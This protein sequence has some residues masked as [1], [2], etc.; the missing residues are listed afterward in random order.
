MTTETQTPD[1]HAP[2]SRPA[3]PHAPGDGARFERRPVRPR[4]KALRILIALLLIAA[5]LGGL[6][7]FNE[8]RKQMIASFFAGNVPPPTPVQVAEA[9]QETVPRHLGAIGTLEAVREVTV[10][11][12]V[13]GRVT[14]IHFESGATVAAGA[15]LVQLNDST[16]RA[17]LLVY[18]AQARLAELNLERSLSLLPRQAVPQTTVDQNRAELDQANANIKRIEAEI[19]QKLIRAPFAGDLGIRAVNLGEFVGAGATLVTLTDLSKLLV[20]FTLPEQ[21]RSR[22]HVGQAVRIESDAFPDRAFDG[23][24][25]TVDPQV[26]AETRAIKIQATLDNPN[27]ELLPG[28]FANVRVVLPAEPNVVVIPE[29]AVDYTLYGDSVFVVRQ[30]A[31]KDG[32]PALIATRVPVETGPRAANRVEIRRGV[33]AGDRVIVSGQLKLSNGAAVAIADATALKTPPAVPNN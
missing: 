29:T 20:N 1:H 23:V 12:E 5:L 27:R 31:G 11:P 24:I 21:N 10:A 32:A 2:A 26:S 13:A 17:D 28:M 8:F 22:L 4:S 15:P 18:R 6:W 7:W 9:V 30:Q 19:A 14:E 25:T 16:E 33:Q 3:A